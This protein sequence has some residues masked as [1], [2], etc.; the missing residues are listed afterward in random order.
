MTPGA[1]DLDV[2]FLLVDRDDEPVGELD[3]SPTYGLGDNVVVDG[4]DWRIVGSKFSAPGD[5]PVLVVER[6]PVR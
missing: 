2:R 6:I 1:Y 3:R 4:K 5:P